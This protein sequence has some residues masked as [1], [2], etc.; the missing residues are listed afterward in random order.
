MHI[1]DVLSVLENSD[2]EGFHNVIVNIFDVV[3]VDAMM[4]LLHSL[5]QLKL[6]LIPKVYA[7]I[8]S[9]LHNPQAIVSISLC[10]SP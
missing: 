2:F 7:S 10:P 9:Q 4:P 8:V 5:P 1:E 6:N 3:L